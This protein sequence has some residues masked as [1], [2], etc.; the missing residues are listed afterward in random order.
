[1]V[2]TLAT[3]KTIITVP[4]A[5]KTIT[6]LT[7]ERIVDN[8]KQQFV[9]AFITELNEPVVLWNQTTTPT[10]ASVGQWTDS[11]VEAR[12]NTLYGGTA[13]VV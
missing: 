1:M 7:V 8:P 5:T 6:T 13:S 12:L 2:V 10:Y 11:D 4:Q 9:R 3:P